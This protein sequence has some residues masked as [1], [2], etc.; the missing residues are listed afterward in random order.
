MWDAV[1][2]Y[3]HTA[4]FFDHFAKAAIFAYHLLVMLPESLVFCQVQYIRFSAARFDANI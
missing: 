4:H 3:L 2:I 1:V